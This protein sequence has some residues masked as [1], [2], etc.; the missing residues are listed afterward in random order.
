MDDYPRA[1][2]PALRSLEEWLDDPAV[3]ALHVNGPDDVWIR[4]SGRLERV[5]AEFPASRVRVLSDAIARLV[6]VDEGTARFGKRFP[7]GIR[8][9][10]V[11]PPAAPDGPLVTLSR[12]PEGPVRPKELVRAGGLSREA[13]DELGS[14]LTDGKGLIVTGP[15][16][17]ARGALLAALSGLLPE[18]ERVVFIDS[19]AGPMPSHPHLVV[20]PVDEEAGLSRADQLDATRRLLPDR[21]II[22]DAGPGEVAAVVSDGGDRFGG[23]LVAV[24][25]PGARAA[26]WRVRAWCRAAGGALEEL[27]PEVFSHVVAAAGGDPAE[28]RVVEVLRLSDDETWPGARQATR[29]RGAECEPIRDLSPPPEA[30]EPAEVRS[31]PVEPPPLAELPPRPNF[32]AGPVA[33]APLEPLPPDP[34][35]VP[36]SPPAA[37]LRAPPGGLDTDPTGAYRA[38]A[39]DETGPVRIGLTSRVRTE[40]APPQQPRIRRVAPEPDQPWSGGAADHD[41]THE[42]AW[43]RTQSSPPEQTPWQPASAEAAAN[44]DATNIIRAIPEDLLDD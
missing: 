34:T 41:S 7:E 38:A 42:D 6:G 22:D 29:E 2:G 26:L 12:R 39:G 25:A 14:A 28:P 35:P 11:R 19:G 17:A 32:P 30:Q 5:S 43:D 13:L 23:G 18:D 3:T 8:A 36:G 33:A 10:V 21:L 24:A 37:P 1:L 9:A 44:Q 40:D 20:L 31:A 15:D 27:L 4:R 16:P